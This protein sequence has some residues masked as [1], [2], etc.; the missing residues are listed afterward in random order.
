M[1]T[2][3][4]DELPNVVI[5]FSQ[6]V[7]LIRVIG[8]SLV[9]SKLNLKAEVIPH[10]DADEVD[11][12]IAFS[13]IRFW[14]E[15]IVSRAVVFSSLNK[16]AKTMFY[17]GEGKPQLMNYMMIAPHEPTDEHLAALF[18]AKMSALS[19]GKMIFGAVRII[20]EPSNGLIWSYIGNWEDDLP[21]MENWFNEDPYYFDQPWW[22]RDDGST[23]DVMI[24]GADVSKRPA[25]AMKLDFIER[26]IRPEM[27]DEE[28]V[29]TEAADEEPAEDVLIQGVFR[30]KIIDTDTE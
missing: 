16:Q 1:M 23:L 4:D 25:W 21:T 6:Q 26:A 28:A 3:E 2:Y 15:T 18:Q 22:A 13:K 30:P 10:E 27:D 24:K 17:D 5:D 19:S 8:N 14:F 12:E 11:F 9:P 7:S 29:A 20:S